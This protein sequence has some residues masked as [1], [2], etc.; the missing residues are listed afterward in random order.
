MTLLQIYI[1]AQLILLILIVLF[2]AKQYKEGEP[3]TKMAVDSLSMTFKSKIGSCP[4]TCQ[5]DWQEK[6]RALSMQAL[7]KM[8]RFAVKY[9]AVMKWGLTQ[10]TLEQRQQIKMLINLSST[11]PEG[12]AIF[13]KT[14]GAEPQEILKF[15]P[16]Y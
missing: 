7:Q 6:N 3:V 2:V 15:M 1:R 4:E 13:K 16:A 8:V 14:F 12:A 10:T 9:P 11:T 5:Q